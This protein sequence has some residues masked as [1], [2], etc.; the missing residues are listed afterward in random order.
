[1]NEVID[2]AS[3][4]MFGDY[5]IVETLG[6]G[7]MGTVYKVRDHK[8]RGHEFVALKVASRAVAD[9]GVLAQRFTKEFNVA[10]ELNH[11]NL[12]ATYEYGI[13]D[14]LPYLVMEYVEGLNLDKRLKRL[15][16]LPFDQAIFVFSQLCSAVSFIHGKDLIHRDIKPGNILID[17]RLHVKLVD[18][19]LIKDCH[20]SELLTDSRVGL[21]T[22]AYAAPCQFSDAKNVDL[23]CDIYSLGVTLYVALTGQSPFGNDRPMRV[24]SRKLNHQFVPISQLLPGID[25]GVEILI[26]RSIHPNPDLRPLSAAEF[27]AELHGKVADVELIRPKPMPPGPPPDDRRRDDRF[28]MEIPVSFETIGREGRKSYNATVLDAS[29]RGA[30]LRCG[31]HTQPGDLLKIHWPANRIEDEQTTET[32]VIWTSKAANNS[33][34]AGCTFLVPLELDGLDRILER[35]ANPT[36]KLM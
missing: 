29:T 27:L 6:Q 14:G 36:E 3:K 13:E 31:R 2:R 4:R 28:S 21:G 7:G 24:L 19:G 9:E 18:L 12:V 34:L 5:E 30:C 17:D 32:R 1:M 20:G 33:L 8:N 35:H 22:V 23:R 11:P 16:P 26:N 25:P 10:V 15:G